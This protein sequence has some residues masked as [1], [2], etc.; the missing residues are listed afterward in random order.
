MIG[1][2]ALSGGIMAKL[3]LPLVNAA[4]GL[5]LSMPYGV[6]V[7][8]LVSLTVVVGLFAGVYPALLLSRFHA[9]DVLASS[10]APD[11]GRARCWSSS[12]SP[13]PSPS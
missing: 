8:A 11:G 6:V 12:S 5:S 10:C 7:P 4:G 9:A 1:I 3:G 13:S 2:A